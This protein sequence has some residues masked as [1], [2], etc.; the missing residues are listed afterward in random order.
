MSNS[1]S[2]PSQKAINERPLKDPLVSH[3]WN[4]RLQN[5]RHEK[6]AVELLANTNFH[7]SFAWICVLR[8]PIALQCS[9]AILSMTRTYFPAAIPRQTGS[10]FFNMKN[11][12]I[13][14]LNLDGW[15]DSL[16]IHRFL[17]EREGD[18]HDIMTTS[19][20]VAR[21]Q[22]DGREYRHGEILIMSGCGNVFWFVP[23]ENGDSI[24]GVDGLIRV[25]RRI[26]VVFCQT[27]VYLAITGE[28]LSHYREQYQNLRNLLRSECLQSR[29]YPLLSHCHRS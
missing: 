2:W 28:H 21:N 22:Y 25:L 11:K 10:P 20:P 27:A 8:Y 19:D 16:W 24:E 15:E 12:D 29:V 4:P 3:L 9:P 18:R 23:W 17:S 13:W 26:P 7:K 6:L 14:L 1:G 5:G